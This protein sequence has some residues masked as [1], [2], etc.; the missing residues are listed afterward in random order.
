MNTK[1]EQEI[2][3]Q[4]DKIKEIKSKIAV[5]QHSLNDCTDKVNEHLKFGHFFF[6]AESNG[7]WTLLN[8]MYPDFSDTG[9]S[10]AQALKRM[11]NIHGNL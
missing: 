9:Y 11:D 6:K 5:L 1:R 7:T 10:L 2:L 3:A 4:M 8:N